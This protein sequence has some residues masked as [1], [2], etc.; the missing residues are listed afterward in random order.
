MADAGP[1]VEALVTL[2]VGAG[3]GAAVL[4]EVLEDRLHVGGGVGGDD[5]CLVHDPPDLQQSLK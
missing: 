1:P 2:P 4:V 5:V 3:H